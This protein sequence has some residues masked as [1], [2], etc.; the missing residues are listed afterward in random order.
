MK[1]KEKVDELI[2][3]FMK[4]KPIKLN[5]YSRIEYPTAK[6]FALFTVDEIL[7]SSKLTPYTFTFVNYND[8]D[9]LKANVVAEIELFNIY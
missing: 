8:T 1:P 6:A 3:S 5:D 9:N 4:H 7:N 2:N